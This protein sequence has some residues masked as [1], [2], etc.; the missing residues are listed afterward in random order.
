MNESVRTVSKKGKK[1]KDYPLLPSILTGFV[2]GLCNGLLGAGGGMIAVMALER[3]CRLETKEAHATAL[4]IMLPLTAISSLVYALGNPLPWDVLLYVGPALALGSL[5]GAKSMKKV[6]DKALRRIFA[7][8][9]LF[10]GGW[11][12]Q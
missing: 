5:L 6:P 7:G 3:F 8:L 4:V 11:M 12:L 2:T 1:G 10:A 9:M